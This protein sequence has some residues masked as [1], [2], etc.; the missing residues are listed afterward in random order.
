MGKWT[1]GD[2]SPEDEWVPTEHRAAF[3]T[4]LAREVHAGRKPVTRRPVTIR[5]WNRSTG[6]GCVPDWSRAW[7]DDSWLT[8]DGYAYLHVPVVND[9]SLMDDTSHRVRCLV[10]PGDTLAVCEEIRAEEWWDGD[11]RDTDAIV[12]AA[13]GEPAWDVT[14]PAQWVWKARRLMPSCL[15]SGLVRLRLDVVRVYP[16]RLSDVTD[17]EAV[18]ECVAALGYPPTRAGY[19]A[20]WDRMYGKTDHAAARDPWVW[21]LEWAPVGGGDRA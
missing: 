6:K 13:D 15:P 19:L 17:D 2:W 14:R 16:E 11:R 1:V 20:L 9:G 10:D 7:R 5:D 18:L 4:A 8:S 12:Y 3:V 21:R